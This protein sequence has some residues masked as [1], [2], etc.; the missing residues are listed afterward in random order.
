LKNRSN[1]A[2]IAIVL[3][4]LAVTSTS[5]A[6]AEEKTIRLG[7]LPT[8]GHVLTFV[9]KEKGFFAEQGLDVQLSQFPNSAD[10]YNALTAGKLDIIAMGSTAPAVYIAKGTDLTYIGGLMGE[11]AAAISLPGRANEFKDIKSFKGKT[12]ATVRMSTGDV[13]FRSALHDAGLNWSKDVTIQELKSP[14]IVLDAV[15]TG[16]VDIGIVWLPYQQVAETQ[17]LKIVQY[18]DSFYPNHPCCRFVV[19]SSTL[20]QDKDTYV[21]FEKAL[22]EAYHYIKTNPQESVDAASKY[23]DFNKNVI[24]DSIFSDHFNYS[25]DPNKKAVEQWWK[26]V[27]TIGYVNSDEDID[28]HIDPT[29]YKQAL[30]ELIKANPN[31]EIYKDLLANYKKNDA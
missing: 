18:G 30:D 22:I 11:G 8:T 28:K 27:N 1:I 14:S 13:V 6:L 9:A 31:D 10:G 5:I 15:K 29:L 23:V 26:M 16:K 24:Y 2:I 7:Y 12:I 3:M 19:K 17:G 20:E 25:P 4:A 21:K